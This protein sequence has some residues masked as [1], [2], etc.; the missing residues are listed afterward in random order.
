M[1]NLN[2]NDNKEMNFNAFSAQVQHTQHSLKVRKENKY[3]GQDHQT[4]GKEN[5]YQYSTVID[6]ENFDPNQAFS[7][8]KFSLSEAETPTGYNL[9][10]RKASHEPEYQPF[11]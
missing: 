8:S 10:L 6:S 5:Y 2:I 4:E 7:V 1:N 11:Q 9:T 3:N